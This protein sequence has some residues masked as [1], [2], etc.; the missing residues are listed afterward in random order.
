MARPL[1]LAP[2]VLHGARSDPRAS[3]S[4]LSVAARPTPDQPEKGVAETNALTAGRN[5]L[6]GRQRACRRRD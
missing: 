2:L 6:G 5:R 3:S 1:A 4:H